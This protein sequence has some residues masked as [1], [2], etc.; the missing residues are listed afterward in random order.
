[1][2]RRNDEGM[3][4]PGS[5]GLNN[6]LINKKQAKRGR[7]RGA[8]ASVR[9]GVRSASRRPMTATDHVGLEIED[10]GLFGAVKSGKNM[11]VR[12]SI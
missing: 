9:G 5:V 8:P 12:A 3:L 2:K 7:G 4:T 11:E 1:M 6:F 10:R